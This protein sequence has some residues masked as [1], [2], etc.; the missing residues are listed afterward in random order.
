M[1]VFGALAL[2]LAT[3]GIYG[4]VAY[5]VG[6]RTREVGIRMAVGADQADVYRLILNDVLMTAGVGLA[7]GL[8]L[9]LWAGRLIENLLFGVTATDGGTIVGVAGLIGVVAMAAGF[10]PARRAAGIEPVRALRE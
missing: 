10:L 4:V 6:L 7:V 1:G 3:V 2:L 8:V 9:A 5:T